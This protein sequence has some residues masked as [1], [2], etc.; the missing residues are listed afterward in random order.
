[1]FTGSLSENMI[2]IGL[3]P[4]IRQALFDDAKDAVMSV[5]DKIRDILRD[6]HQERE[7]GRPEAKR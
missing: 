4:L 1:M 7:R 3:P 5:Q 6:W 2:R